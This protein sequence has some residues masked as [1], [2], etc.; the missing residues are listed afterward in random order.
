[1]LE[2]GFSLAKELELQMDLH[3]ALEPMPLLLDQKKLLNLHP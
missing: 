2:K 3:L 1:M